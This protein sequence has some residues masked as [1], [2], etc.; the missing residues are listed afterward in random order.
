MADLALLA[1]EAQRLVAET[2]EVEQ[3]NIGI[4]LMVAS[5]GRTEVY[6]D[7][8]E[9][10]SGLTHGLHGVKTIDIV[11]VCPPDT[12]KAANANIHF[13]VGR[14]GWVEVEGVD[15]VLVEGLATAVREVG[16]RGRRSGKWLR[17][18]PFALLGSALGVWFVGGVVFS[19]VRGN[20]IAG[21]LAEAAIFAL[22]VAAGVC[23]LANWAIP[24]VELRMSGESTRLERLVLRP[25]KWVALTAVGAGLTTLVGVLIAHAVR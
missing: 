13:C 7:V 21:R 8:T 19:F 5:S 18:A 4:S 24:V 22:F 3:S 25:L 11:T 1:R 16:E 12:K 20:G 15:R 6:K 23:A 2:L 14:H 10:E 17:P 9:F